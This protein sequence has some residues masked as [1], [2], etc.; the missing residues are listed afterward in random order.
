MHT[1]ISISTLG[2][3]IAISFAT[4]TNASAQTPA[5]TPK[6]I[7][8]ITK[9]PGEL[10][11]PYEKWQLPNGLTILIHE[12]HSDPILYTDVTYHVGS[13]REQAGRSGFALFF[14]H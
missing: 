9:K 11:I 5:T 6:M 8:K 4:T 14:E 12:D 2:I 3:A 7:E 10:I 13:N 1:K